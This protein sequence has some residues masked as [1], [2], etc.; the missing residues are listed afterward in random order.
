MSNVYSCTFSYSFKRLLASK[1]SCYQRHELFFFVICELL[2]SC[3]LFTRN[4]GVKALHYLEVQVYENLAVSVHVSWDLLVHVY[5]NS[6]SEHFYCCCFSIDEIKKLRGFLHNFVFS[7]VFFFWQFNL[8][9]V[10]GVLSR[11]A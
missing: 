1:K 6:D 4:K 11:S 10:C 3:A 8:R 5:G 2:R 7:S 9:R